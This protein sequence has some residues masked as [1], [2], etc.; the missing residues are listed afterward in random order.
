MISWPLIKYVLTAAKRDRLAF[1]LLLLMAVAASLSILM[2][3]TAVVEKNNFAVVFMAGSLRFVT[4]LGLVLFVVSYI[5]RAFDTKDVEYLLSRPIGRVSFVLSH[6]VA[7]SI[8][9]ALTGAVASLVVIGIAGN[10]TDNIILW[11]ASLIVELVIMVNAAMFFALVLPST[12][13][14]ALA[15]LALYALARLMGELLGILDHATAQELAFL[16]VLSVVMQAV[17]LIVPRLD[18]LGQTSW[19]IYPDQSGVTGLFLLTQMV[20]YTALV[21]AASIVDLSRRQF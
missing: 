2:G 3:S 5:R 7:F 16:P 12:T 8:L 20:V 11:S 13:M 4:M 15:T 9:A 10:L 21:M 1:S 19:L 6:G 18:L 17:S 14:S